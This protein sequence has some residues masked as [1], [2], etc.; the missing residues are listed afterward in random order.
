MAEAGA[1]DIDYTVEAERFVTVQVA[2]YLQDRPSRGFS[3]PAE[4]DAV[5][6]MIR[7]AWVELRFSA[8][9]DGLSRSGR[10]ALYW[11]TLIAF[12]TFIADGGLDCIPVDFISRQRVGEQI[13][14]APKRP[15]SNRSP[16]LLGQ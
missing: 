3:G 8:G 1:A 2:R 16:G 10:E 7:D 9:L 14:V 13:L 12:P 5:L 4:Y 6:A 15:A 11:T